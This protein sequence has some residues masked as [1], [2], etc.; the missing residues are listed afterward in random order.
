MERQRLADELAKIKSS[1]EYELSKEKEDEA[2]AELENKVQARVA[3]SM[4]ARFVKGAQFT[5]KNSDFTNG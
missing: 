4:L 2:L 1:G 3:D 5:Q